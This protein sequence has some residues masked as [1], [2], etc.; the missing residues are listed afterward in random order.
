M[1]K[2]AAR[3]LV[4]DLESRNSLPPE[5]GGAR[6]KHPSTSNIEAVVHDIQQSMQSSQHC[7]IATFYLEDAYNKVEVGI[8]TQKMIALDISPILIRWILAML[9]SRRC[10]MQ[11]GQWSSD[12]FKVSSGLPQGSPLRPVLFNI[13]TA[14]LV[15]PC[16][17]LEYIQNSMS[18]IPLYTA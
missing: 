1:E 11:F 15:P 13:Y 8:L 3:R 4:R 5:V 17:V 16:Q 2:V 10:Q 12:V 6:P 18:M 9:D 7:A 14:D